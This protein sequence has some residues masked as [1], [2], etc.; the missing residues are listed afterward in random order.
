MDIFKLLNL[1]HIYLN[2]K[3][4]DFLI[5]RLINY[6]SL[7][8]LSNVSNWE[9]QSNESCSKLFGSERVSKQQWDVLQSTKPKP[10]IPCL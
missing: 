1:I 7:S 2:N 8:L 3:I 6:P 9:Y 4:I 5:S 10:C